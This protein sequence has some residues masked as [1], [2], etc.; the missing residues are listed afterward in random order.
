[1]LYKVTTLKLFSQAPSLSLVGGRKPEQAREKTCLF[2][3][4]TR[5]SGRMLRMVDQSLVNSQFRYQTPRTFEGL[6]TGMVK[7][8]MKRF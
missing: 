2:V 4:L 3:D 8:S 5:Q 7:S 1:M 6:L